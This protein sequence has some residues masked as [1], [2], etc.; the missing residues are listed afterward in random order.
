LLLLLLYYFYYLHYCRCCR[1]LRIIIILRLFIIFLPGII[2][3][4]VASVN[5]PIGLKYV[6]FFLYNIMGKSAKITYPNPYPIHTRIQLYDNKCQY[7]NPIL[8]LF[9]FLLMFFFNS[10]SCYYAYSCS[11]FYFYSSY[12]S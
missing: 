2:I 6:A 5:T 10:C 1:Y 12:Y 9:L 11:Y 7:K 3:I 4:A 8:C